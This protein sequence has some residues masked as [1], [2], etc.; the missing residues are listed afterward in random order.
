MVKQLVICH[1]ALEEA[2][3]ILKEPAAS[4]FRKCV[5]AEDRYINDSSCMFPKM[6]ETSLKTYTVLQ[7][8]KVY[9]INKLLW[10][11]QMF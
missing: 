7:P 10:K 1:K 2:C 11:P 8:R 9:T 6:C 4:V 5:N 3:D